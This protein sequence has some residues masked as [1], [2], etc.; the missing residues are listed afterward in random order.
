MGIIR[1]PISK[2][3]KG[4]RPGQDIIINGKTVIVRKNEEI[5]NKTID[6]LRYN[7]FTYVNISI[8]T[9]NNN[10][11]LD[12]YYCDIDNDK[13]SSKETNKMCERFK[14]QVVKI[15]SQFN[16][17]LQGTEKIDIGCIVDN[18]KLL[19]TEG[20]GIYKIFDA[21]Y[22]MKNFDDSTYVHSLNVGMVATVIAEWSNMPD[23]VINN[24]TIAGI[25]H[26]IGKTQ[27]PKNILNKPSRLTADEFGVVKKHAEL[28]YNIIRSLDIPE[29]S[30]LA[31]IQ[32]HEKCD[33]SGYPY[34]LTSNEI[35]DVSKIITI[36]DIYDAMTS[37]RCYRAP[38]CPF[39]VMQ[40]FEYEGMSKFEPRFLVPFFKGIVQTYLNKYVELSNGEKGRVV[41]MH[42]HD[43]SRPLIKTKDKFI[44][45]SKNRDIKVKA[46]I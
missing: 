43:I 12:D 1:I 30:K 45:L 18:I 42:N 26:D 6:K 37:A 31:V 19:A 27:I 36:A 46:I 23:D 3:K 38:I 11:N 9:S 41:M 2:V 20:D 39:E 16:E 22:N 14:D 21:L 34:G 35:S 24:V 40:V 15:E 13:S 33:G 17:I 7:G 5:T 4:M 10:Y 28:G 8:D 44:D 25:V 32:H 29:D